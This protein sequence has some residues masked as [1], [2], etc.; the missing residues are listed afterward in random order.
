MREIPQDALDALRCFGFTETEALVYACLCTNPPTTAYG[1]A[2]MIGKPTANVYKAVAKLSE[3]GAVFVEDG[4]ARRCRAVPLEDVVE[5]QEQML[6]ECSRKATASLASLGQ[7]HVDE[8]VY[9]IETVSLVFERARKILRGCRKIAVVD[10]FPRALER[11]LP[12]LR[13]TMERGIEV[14]VEAYAPVEIAGARVA[15]VPQGHR[16]LALWQSEQ[17]NLVGDGREYLAALLSADLTQ[18]FQAVW[19]RSRFLSCLHHAGRL[20][21]NTVV[22]LLECNGDPQ[23]MAEVLAEHRFFIDGEVPGQQEIVSLMDNAPQPDGEGE[24]K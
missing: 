14:V 3:K 2:K 19:S 16:T 23:R 8:N 10:A 20:C 5:R 7:R 4:A 18:V 1:I 9:R 11:L 13:A 15:V 22:R 17:L 21:E 12:D 6:R 24:N